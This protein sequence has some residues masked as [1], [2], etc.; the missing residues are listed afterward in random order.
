MNKF[1]RAAFRTVLCT[2]ATLAFAAPSPGQKYSNE[3]LSIGV[4]A[5]AQAMG[6]A[7]VAGVDDVSAGMWNPAALTGIP[8]DVGLQIAAMHSEWFAGVGK[9]DYAGILIPLTNSKRRLA[10]SVVRFGIDEIPNTLTLYESDGS[11]NFDNV[12]EFSAADYAALLSYAQV[13]PSK[14]GQLSVGGNVKVVHRRIGPFAVA[15]GFGID[16]AGHYRVNQWRFGLLAQDITTT[17]N[18]WSFNFN[19]REKEVLQITNN[20]APINSIELTRPKLIFGAAREWRFNKV[21]LLPEL[22]WIV[23]TDGR[24]NTLISSKPFS[25]DP[26]FGIEADYNRFIFVRAGV[27]Q[28]QRFTDF[29]GRRALTLRP[30]IG[31]GFQ[32]GALKIDYAFT[33]LGDSRNTFSHVFSL[34]LNIR[35]RANG[36]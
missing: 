21:G 25:V 33:D 12:S 16:L 2:V 19:E 18:A 5:R 10:L 30:S 31:A 35:R 22:N 29:D 6:N 8:A 1:Y 11:I 23:S 20:E 17:F 36:N 13:L 9:F 15:W 27:N 32:L 34:L 24:R 14:S 26:G 28:F 3:F 7:V 4:G